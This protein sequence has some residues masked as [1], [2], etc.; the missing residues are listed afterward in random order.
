MAM[1]RQQELMSDESPK[2]AHNGDEN[3]PRTESKRKKFRPFRAVR[4]MFRKRMRRQ[5]SENLQD[6][7]KSRSTTELQSDNDSRRRFSN[8]N[9]P[10]SVGLSVS[11]DSIFSPD[12]ATASLDPQDLRSIHGFLSVQHVELKDLKNELFARVRARRDSDDEDAGLPHSPCTSPTT[13]DVLSQN[14]K[15]KS[16]I[17]RTTCSEGSLI[18]MGSSEN[19]EDLMGMVLSSHSSRMSLSDKRFQE[20]DEADV[21]QP[22]PL[23]HKAAHH[24]IA[25]RPKRTHGLPRHRKQ[26][27]AASKVGS[28]PSTPEISEDSGRSSSCL[29]QSSEIYVS[30]VESSDTDIQS[31]AASLNFNKRI[32]SPRENINDLMTNLSPTSPNEH[33]LNTNNLKSAQNSP[34]ET[35][36][37]WNINGSFDNGCKSV[38]ENN[39]SPQREN[40]TIDTSNE[41]K[42]INKDCS[43]INDK[44][45]SPQD[46]NEKEAKGVFSA[47]GA[48]VRK[49]SDMD[50]AEKNCK[51][52]QDDESSE[53]FL[54]RWFGSRRSNRTNKRNND[55]QHSSTPSPKEEIKHNE[56][57]VSP[58]ADTKSSV[59]CNG[60]NDNKSNTATE[61][62]NLF[63]NLNVSNMDNGTSLR[64]FTQSHS[65]SFKEKIVKNQNM[66]EQYTENEYKQ[67]SNRLVVKSSSDDCVHYSLSSGKQDDNPSFQNQKPKS[68][69]KCQETELESKAVTS[70]LTTWADLK[71]AQSLKQDVTSNSQQKENSDTAYTEAQR[72]KTFNGHALD[73]IS[74]CERPSSLDITKHTSDDE[75]SMESNSS[76]SH[77]KHNLKNLSSNFKQEAINEANEKDMIKRLNEQDRANKNIESTVPT[78]LKSETKIL[79][80]N[81][82]S[83]NVGHKANN[84]ENKDVKPNSVHAENRLQ[85][86]LNSTNNA[87]SQSTDNTK[88]Q[89]HVHD[90][91]GASPKQPTCNSNN[92]PSRF[93][94]RSSN[95]VSKADFKSQPTT[96]GNT[97]IVRKS[98]E[99]NGKISSDSKPDKKE[100]NKEVLDLSQIEQSKNGG[101]TSPKHVEETS[102]KDFQP[103]NSLPPNSELF[104]VFARRS[105]KQKHAD[106]EK[107]SNKPPDVAVS[108]VVN[109]QEDLNAVNNCVNTAISLKDKIAD[110]NTLE[111]MVQNDKVGTVQ[112]IFIP[113]PRIVPASTQ[114]KESNVEK[115]SQRNSISEITQEIH[116]PRPRSHTTSEP[117]QSSDSVP[118]MRT[119]KSSVPESSKKVFMKSKEEPGDEVKSGRAVNDRDKSKSF[120]LNNTRN[121]P[122]DTRSAD[123]NLQPSWLRL[124]Q[125]R[126]E[127]REQKEK[128]LLGSSS[129]PATEMN[130]KPVRST[131][132]LDMVSNFQK[133]QMT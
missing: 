103:D 64:N 39:I 4:N 57:Q 78:V 33:S 106:K 93:L 102:S 129:P 115:R 61:K 24:K 71:K 49:S 50:K 110:K 120:K 46:K 84:S 41:E 89:P 31:V 65:D 10:Y 92:G 62:K 128:Q 6:Y 86:D 105:I 90:I 35:S 87:I 77:W 1:A 96:N 109:G 95:S 7:K 130:T 75:T 125:Q 76:Y 40:R 111:T 124:A 97:F 14:L 101:K 113:R 70:T 127:Q 114:S 104:R 122:P 88:E 82:E 44:G 100:T 54:S 94:H 119:R 42:I 2:E 9:A 29:L 38:E 47:W 34:S 17:S 68:P 58:E 126:R 5:G 63:L 118:E 112:E 11:H 66:L 43:K 22:V 26:Q 79:E 55:E 59:E 60:K 52:E 28:L 99:S 56:K 121:S 51:N 108:K 72:V 32:N 132:V 16:G 53:P 25:V 73:K 36:N 83:G 80:K 131:K 133:L 12:H 19:D 20:S 23:S 116:I 81:Q 85:K 69:E 37:N 91:P 98:P 45:D 74:H 123:D 67:T 107:Q 30:E 3:P 8:P 13:A 21:S 27:L 117:T 48:K 15:S 18:S